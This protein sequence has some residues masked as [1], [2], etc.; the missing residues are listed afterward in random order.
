MARP[1]LET[2]PRTA[3]E[4]QAAYRERKKAAG[5]KRKD[6]WIDPQVSS[7]GSGA[8]ALRIRG[9]SWVRYMSMR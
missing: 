3:A 6:G 9:G 5:L 7:S 2:G 8:R 4:R 1:K